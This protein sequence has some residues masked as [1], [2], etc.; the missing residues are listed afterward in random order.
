MSDNE[1]FNENEFEEIKNNSKGS[2]KTVAISSFDDTIIY[3]PIFLI[4]KRK[5]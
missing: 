5:I 1:F 3:I 4:L 2:N